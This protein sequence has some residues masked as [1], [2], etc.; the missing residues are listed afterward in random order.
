MWHWPLGLVV[1]LVAS[2]LILFGCHVALR[3]Q[4]EAARTMA[5]ARVSRRL[6]VTEGL[7]EPAE[8]HTAQLRHMLANIE[9]IR[10]GA[11]APVSQQPL[12]K[13]LLL[14]LSA[15]GLAILEYFGVISF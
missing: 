1:P 8:G 5:V 10:E 7:G 4:A 11:Y 15:S 2:L 14:F 13:A 12:V 6:L 3:R 9:D